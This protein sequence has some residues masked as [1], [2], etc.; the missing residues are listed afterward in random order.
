MRFFYLQGFALSVEIL[1]LACPRESIQREGHPEHS[2]ADADALRSS[3]IRGCAQLAT[4]KQG[5][6]LIPDYLRYSVS[7]DGNRVADS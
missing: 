2:S 4:L 1:S 5:A 3:T 6:H 7:A